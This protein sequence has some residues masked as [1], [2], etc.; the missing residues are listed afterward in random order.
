MTT[1]VKRK[2]TTSITFESDYYKYTVNQLTLLKWFLKIKGMDSESIEYH[3]RNEIKDKMKLIRENSDGIVI[4]KDVAELM[5]TAYKEIS[6]CVIKFME[7]EVI[8]WD[9]EEEENNLSIIKTYT[10]FRLD[11]EEK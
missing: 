4:P 5:I 6:T 10:N 2:I 3:V 9:L 11:E 8:N 1:D 7:E